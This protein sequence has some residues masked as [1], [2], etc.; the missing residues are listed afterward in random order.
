MKNKANSNVCL[1]KCAKCKLIRI[2]RRLNL[3]YQDFS[4][5]YLRGN[6]KY[7]DPKIRRK[8]Y[9]K[10]WIYH[11]ENHNMCKSCITKIIRS[12]TE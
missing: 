11:T 2:T 8:P 6:W 5:T 4:K 7:D 9:A 10:M 12:I 1:H 3:R